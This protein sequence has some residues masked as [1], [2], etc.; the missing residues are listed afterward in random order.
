MIINYS[1]QKVI[2][3]E[4]SIFLAGPTPRSKDVQTWR[5]EAV[6][7]LKYLGFDGVVYVPELE[8]DDRTFNYDNQVWWER[9]ALYNASIIVFWVPRNMKTIPAL[10]TNVEYGYWISKNPD[11]IIYGRPDDSEKNKYLDWLYEVETGKEPINDLSNLLKE[12]IKMAN[13]KTH[14]QYKKLVRDN[15]PEII[16]KNG[17]EPV[18]RILS[19]EEYK[20][21]LEKK[22]LEECKEVLEA[23]DEKRIEELAD[24][25]EVMIA[26]GK[27]EGKTFE[28]IIITCEEKRTKRGSFD[29]RIYLERVRKK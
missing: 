13:N 1:N 8:N 27:I 19:Q 18:T 17:E 14:M 6:E 5:T 23:Q 20:I 22:L 7:I 21:E 16:R 25:L 24:L 12:A 11:K 2:K 9:E 29:K 10:T 28:D 15:I 4:K 26:L 3:E